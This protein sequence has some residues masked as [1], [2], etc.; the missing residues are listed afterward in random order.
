MGWMRRVKST[1]LRP[2]RERLTRVVVARPYELRVSDQ[3]R[4]AGMT[5]VVTGGSGAIGRAIALHLSAEGAHVYAIGRSE[6]RLAE[7]ARDAQAVGGECTPARVDVTD[8]GEVTAFFSGLERVDI[9]VNCAGGSSRAANGPVWSVPLEVVDRVLA[10]NLR[11]AIACTRAAA[12]IMVAQRSG[13]IINVGSIIGDRG[14][15]GFADYAAA[16]AG[17]AAYSRSAAL[18]LGSSGVTV[19]CVSPGIVLRGEPTLAEVEKTRATNVLHRVGSAEDVAQAISFFAGPS[20]GFITGQ[21]L[22]VDGGRSLGL[23]GDD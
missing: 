6:Q 9:L 20:A 3:R 8:D 21:D 10:V 7:V 13:R 4:L 12:A 15:A 17:L 1:F 18:E 5:A 19:N 14:K 22:H 11:A 16:K 2:L 23:R